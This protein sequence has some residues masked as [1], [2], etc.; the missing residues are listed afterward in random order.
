MD[1]KIQNM[2]RTLFETRLKLE[3]ELLKGDSFLLEYIENNTRTTK[4][5]KSV[6]KC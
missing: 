4:I 2:I 1:G 5:D 3:N 6:Y